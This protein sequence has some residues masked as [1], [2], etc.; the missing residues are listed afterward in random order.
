MAP[1]VA[2]SVA[3]HQWDKD[4]MPLF[5]GFISISGAVFDSAPLSS[6]Q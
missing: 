2:P 3:V 5:A 1:A 6:I 4:C